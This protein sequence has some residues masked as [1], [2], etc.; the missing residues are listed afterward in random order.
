MLDFLFYSILPFLFILGFCITIHELGHFIFAKISKIPVE[1]FSIGFGP[2][3]V[4]MKIGETDFRIAYF[5][6][7]G[8]VKMAGEDEGEIVKKEQ[9]EKTDIPGFYDAPIWKRIAV[10]FC[11]PLFNILSAFIVLFVIILAYG[12]ITTPFMKITVDEPSYYARQGF[13]TNDSIIAVNGVRVND[14]EGL[15]DIVDRTADD[16]VRVTVVRKD[17]VHD[18]DARIDEDSTGMVPIVPPIAGALKQGS[19]AYKAGM[20]QGDS[21]VSIND[22]VISNWSEMVD[23]VRTAQ[24]KPLRFAWVHKGDTI[25]AVITPESFYDPVE[26]DT[27]GQIGVFMPHG[28]T[29][30]SAVRAFVVSVQRTTEMIYRVLE[31]F[32][33]L[34]TRQIP[35]RQLGGPIAIFR[36]STESAQWGFEYLLGLLAIISVNL[37]LINLFPIPALDG[38]HIIVAAIEAIRHKRFSS[39]TRLIIQQIGYALIFMLIIFVTFNDITR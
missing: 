28:R 23:I 37:G 7:G 33:Q 1:K 11:G 6:F 16:R 3:L 12:V 26:G 24:N 25:T 34:I 4:R 30:V 35:A 17:G 20:K 13:T 29:P 31:V 15:W 21:I 14:W 39:K 38:G 5:P 8:Y 32:Y 19:P 27:I 36:L 9:P 18:I 10:V 2:P 22:T